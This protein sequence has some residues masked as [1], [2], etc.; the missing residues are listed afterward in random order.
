MYLN[1]FKLFFTKFYTCPKLADGY[2]RMVRRQALLTC[3]RGCRG[4]RNLLYSEAI[5]RWQHSD[6]TTRRTTE[7]RIR[8]CLPHQHP[9]P[10]AATRSLGNRRDPWMPHNALL[11]S[12]HTHTTRHSLYSVYLYSLRVSLWR[13]TKSTH[14]AVF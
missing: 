14:Y 5:A 12:A 6:R 4:D 3:V 8:S 11:V 2:R 13:T 9:L 7:L 1:T 10:A